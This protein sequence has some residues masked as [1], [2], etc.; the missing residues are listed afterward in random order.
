MENFSCKIS[1]FAYNN[2]LED[3][4]AML[5][6]EAWWKDSSIKDQTPFTLFKVSTKRMSV[7]SVKT[8]KLVCSSI[9]T[10]L[11]PPALNQST[12]DRRNRLEQ[13]IVQLSGG[14]DASLL[15]RGRA[16]RQGRMAGNNR[17]LNLKLVVGIKGLNH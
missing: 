10:L 13:L 5:S 2:T 14:G 6:D 12:I 1:K 17:S 9:R 15:I 11:S 8:A 3:K 16:S 7:W 4:R